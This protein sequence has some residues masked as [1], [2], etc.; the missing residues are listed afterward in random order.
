MN[1]MK[2]VAGREQRIRGTHAAKQRTGKP[3]VRRLSTSGR[4]YFI[5][6]WMTPRGL[7]REVVELRINKPVA[8]WSRNETTGVLECHWRIRSSA[9]ADTNA[10]SYSPRSQPVS[11]VVRAR[12]DGVHADMRPPSG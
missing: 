9:V 12:R 10:S 11:H 6:Y 8:S 4:P 7:R 3:H 5:R 1:H 2:S